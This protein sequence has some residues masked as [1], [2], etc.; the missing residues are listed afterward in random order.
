MI[1]A[2][3]REHLDELLD[4]SSPRTTPITTDVAD[5]IT[6]LQ[7]AT[8]ASWSSAARRSRWVR[9]VVAGF[10]AVLL[11]GGVATAAAAV[12]GHWTLP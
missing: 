5:E 11:V 3:D 1:M 6:R 7:T 2:P 12:T 8:E 10:A 4:Q 9:P